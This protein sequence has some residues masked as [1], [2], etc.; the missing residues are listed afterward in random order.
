MKKHTKPR[1]T[2]AQAANPKG[3]VRIIAGRWR[4]R[5]LPVLNAQ[6]LRPTGDRIKETLFNWLMPYIAGANCLDAFA[7]SGSLG[8]E[9][10]SRQAKSVTFLELDKTVA[11]QLSKNLQTLNCDKTQASVYNQNSLEFLKQVQNRPHFD[12]VFLDPPFN[13]G[14]AEQAIRLLAENN[15][16]RPDALIYVETEREKQPDVP[17]NWMLLKEKTSGQVS[18][19]LYRI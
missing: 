14:L 4:G 16:L 6:G 9:A 15:W 12:V 10:L 11:R 7:G 1:N 8:F 19:R 17:E 3:E 2:A 18:Y 13:F 5:K